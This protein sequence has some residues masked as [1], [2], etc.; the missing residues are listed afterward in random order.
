M[1]ESTRTEF[2]GAAPAVGSAVVDEQLVASWWRGPA[3]KG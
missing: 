2:N 3:P 1:T